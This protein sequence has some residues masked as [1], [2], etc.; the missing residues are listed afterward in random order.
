MIACQNNR[1]KNKFVLIGIDASIQGYTLGT[2]EV[3]EFPSGVVKA[4]KLEIRFLAELDQKR[5]YDCR[6]G[7]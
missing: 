6:F 1:A 2:K 3:F 5:N 7:K 4:T